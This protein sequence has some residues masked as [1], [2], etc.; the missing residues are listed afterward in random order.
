MNNSCLYKCNFKE[1]GKDR[2]YYDFSNLIEMNRY[3]L[4][5]ASGY[6]A[7]MG[8]Y[9]SKLLLCTELA[10]KLINQESVW[11]VM[12]N[13]YRNSGPDG[14]KQACMNHLIGQ[15]VMTK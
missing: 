11:D 10:H 5:I 1:F 6:K 13:F 8:L 15:T 9:G 4:K 3:S 14:Y 7:S 2:A 12:E